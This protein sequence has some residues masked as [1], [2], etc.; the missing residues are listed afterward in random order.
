MIVFCGTLLSFAQLYKFHG[1]RVVD[2]LTYTE[3]NKRWISLTIDE[4]I[5]K[6]V[7][8][9]SGRN[10]SDLGQEYQHA[11]VSELDDA[12]T[13]LLGKTDLTC[14]D[15]IVDIRSTVIILARASSIQNTNNWQS[16]AT[17]LYTINL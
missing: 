15:Q 10:R 8:V 9:R 14:G 1:R 2:R 7:P 17:Y 6:S 12:T 13:Q 5:L 16:T 3:G 4:N 11:A